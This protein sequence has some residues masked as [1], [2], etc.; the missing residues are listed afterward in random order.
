MVLDRSDIDIVNWNDVVESSVRHVRWNPDGS[1]FFVKFTGDCPSW[2]VNK[3]L[4]TYSKMKE[5]LLY[6]TW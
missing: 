6:D 4:Y 2:G 3:P 1:R 5:M